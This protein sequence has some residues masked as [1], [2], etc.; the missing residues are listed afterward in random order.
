M[1][2]PLLS[3]NKINETSVNKNKRRFIYDVINSL[4]NILSLFK[5][6]IGNNVEEK[7]KIIYYV[8]LMKY[9]NLSI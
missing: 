1:K 7:N 8:L 4:K 3:K 6:S 5:F 2:P 9:L